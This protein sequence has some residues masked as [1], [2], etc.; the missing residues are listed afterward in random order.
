MKTLLPIK[1]VKKVWGEEE[2]LVNQEDIPYCAKI[3]YLDKGSFC[4]YHY[5][6]RKEETFYVLSGKIKFTFEG[7]IFEIIKGDRVH[8]PPKT[9]HMFEGIEYSEIL[10][11]STFHSDDD[12]VR[13]SESGKR[14]DI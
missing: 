1:R 14:E 10:E 2:W 5:H 3:L 4:S 11:S 7:K 9:K 8:I 6:P 12:V 13:L